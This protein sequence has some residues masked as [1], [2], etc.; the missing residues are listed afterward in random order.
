M[1]EKTVFLQKCKVFQDF[2]PGLWIQGRKHCWYDVT[3]IM[4]YMKFTEIH[5]NWAEWTY[6]YI[7]CLIQFFRRTVALEKYETLH[8]GWKELWEDPRVTRESGPG[9]RRSITKEFTTAVVQS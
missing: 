1:D 3:Q 2:W 7:Q 6:T 5:Q 9:K 4:N 8:T